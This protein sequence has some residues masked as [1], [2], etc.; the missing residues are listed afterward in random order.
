[1]KFFKQIIIATLFLAIAGC[2]A[3]DITYIGETLKPTKE[4]QI[5]FNAKNIHRPYDVMGKVIA[6]AP[7]TFT[8][9]EIQKKILQTAEM[10]GADAVLV[11]LY[12]QIPGGSSCF[13]DDPYDYGYGGFD[14]GY[15]YGDG[16]Y[17]G[18][19]G[20]NDGES[21]EFYYQVLIKAEFLRYKTDV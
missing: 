13:N 20:W 17:N 3:I 16:F 6:R 8:G 11:T 7:N 10:K 5:F 1:M 12:T 9:Q 14:G 19:G 4:A 21:V 2:E 18:F 15:G